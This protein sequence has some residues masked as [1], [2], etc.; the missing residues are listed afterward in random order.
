[1]GIDARSKLVL[2]SVRLCARVTRREARNFYWGLRLT[3]EPR[4]GALYAI[5][6]WMRHADD[7]ADDEPDPARAASGLAEMRELTLRVVNDEP[8]PD[9]GFW[10]AF[11]WA[12]R[13][14]AIEPRWL[15]DMLDGVCEDLSHQ[16]YE[17][18]QDL[19]RY[20]YRVGGTVG[21]C[22][23]AIWG[24]RDGA[25]RDVASVA[26]EARGRGFQMINI[27]RD[28][29]TDAAGPRPR[30]YVPRETLRA[31]GISFEQLRTCEDPARCEALLRELIGVAR[32]ELAASAKLDD[33]IAKD[34]TGVLSVMTQIYSD[35]LA[36]I[37]ARPIESLRRGPMRVPLWRKM[38]IM[39]GAQARQRG[40]DAAR[41]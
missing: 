29:A 31:H 17:T 21:L 28:I 20:R 25:D 6:A 4:R 2:D 34:C 15:I 22:S 5:Y 1:V 10:P 18:S 9:E 3:P 40:S 23:M 37:E 32:G 14:H 27:L 7:L 11:A 41:Q 26:A 30:V 38:A 35:L 24:L 19:A 33:L 16:G 36:R 8:V 39:W 13:G 12:A